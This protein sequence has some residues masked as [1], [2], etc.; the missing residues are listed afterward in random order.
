MEEKKDNKLIVMDVMPILYR[1]HFA[2]INRPRMTATGINTSSISI[3]AQIGDL[4]ISSL[5]RDLGVKHSGS[6]F[7]EYGGVLDRMDAFIFSAP[8]LYYILYLIK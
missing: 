4:T 5:K 1:G 2:L 6:L 3:F 7:L 8:A